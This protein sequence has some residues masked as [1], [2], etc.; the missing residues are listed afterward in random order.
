[1]KAFIRIE[2]QHAVL[3]KFYVF[4]YL[5]YILVFKR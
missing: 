3:S 2:W 4:N 1:M 5:N